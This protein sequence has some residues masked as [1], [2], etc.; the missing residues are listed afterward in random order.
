MSLGAARESY[1]VVIDTDTLRVDGEATEKR[2]QS[3]RTAGGD[4]KM[5]HRFDYFETEAEEL[6]WVEGNMPRGAR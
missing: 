1:G 3:I 5:F 6:A 2:R 4:T